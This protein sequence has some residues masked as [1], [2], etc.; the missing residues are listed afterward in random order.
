DIDREYRT[1]CNLAMINALLAMGVALF[2][3]LI[4]F[5]ILLSRSVMFQLLARR[6][7]LRRKAKA[8]AMK[9][10]TGKK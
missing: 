7:E 1:A 4:A 10:H 3:P 8:K 5:V 9:E 6:F 2:W